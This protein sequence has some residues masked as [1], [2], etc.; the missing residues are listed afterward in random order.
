[1]KKVKINAAL[2]G[3]EK[4]RRSDAALLF[5]TCCHVSLEQVKTRWA[6]YNTR[7]IGKLHVAV[8]ADTNPPTIQVHE[9]ERYR[10]YITAKSSTQDE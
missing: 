6:R 8:P 5:V 4:G 10:R 3:M 1:V 7:A 9:L 2:T